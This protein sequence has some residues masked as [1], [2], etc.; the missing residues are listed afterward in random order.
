MKGDAMDIIACGRQ[1]NYLPYD[2]ETRLHSVRRVVESGWSI[3]KALSYYKI[4][5]TTFWRWR[6]RYD[7]AKESLMDKSHRPHSEHPRK[8]PIEVVSKIGNFRR[9]NPEDSSVEI[10]VKT[11]KSGYGVSYSTCLRILKRLDGYEPYKTN[12]KKRH[13][14]KYHTPDYPGDKWQVDVKYVPT[15]CKAPGL[16]GRFYQYTYLDEASRKRFL[17]FAN[18]HSM[19]ET[20]KGLRRA[21]AFFGYAPRI[22]Q[23][24]NGF[25]FSDRASAKVDD[26]S[27][28][29]RK[30]PNFLERF[31]LEAD[32]THK[33]IRPRTP[34]HN[35][36]VERSH[37]VDQE[38]FYRT[39]RFHSLKDLREQGARWMR[40]YNKTP[41]M[42][43][44]L[45]S[46]NETEVEKLRKL[47]QDTGEVR[48][49]KLLKCFTSFEN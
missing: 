5:R 4:K 3:R 43:L 26:L 1:R 39:M 18:E 30:G 40:R 11:V 8:T 35:G 9:R 44:N 25:E 23:T 46:P 19:Y 10:W 22:I 15:E 42:T 17:Y 13:D 28:A 14:G 49:L 2:L 36:K 12:P 27:S 31:C 37:R 32:I 6:K 47:M 38:K 41:K 34:E 45:K 16:E 24:D 33:F 20:V 29:G 7:G 21:I 48:C